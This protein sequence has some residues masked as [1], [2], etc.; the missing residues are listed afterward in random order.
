MRIAANLNVKDEIELIG[1][2]INHLFAIGVDVIN[3]FD[4]S[5]T[6]GTA[7]FLARNASD[8]LKLFSLTD[9][10]PNNF[11]PWVELS[12][13]VALAS[14]ADWVVFLDADE[15]WL[16][17]HG[18]IKSSSALEDAD[19]IHVDRFNVPLGVDGPMCPTIFAP[20]NYAC[21]MLITQPV[22]DFRGYLDV[23]PAAPWIRGV[24]G[25]KIM[26]RP[27]CIGDILC[28][29]HDVVPHP[30]LKVRRADAQDIIITHLPFT[31]RERFIRKVDNI[32]HV[33]ATHGD[34]FGQD[35]AWHWRRWLHLAEAGQLNA[36]FDRTVFSPSVTTELQMQGVIRSA[37]QIFADRDKTSMQEGVSSPV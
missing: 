4:I 36:E 18:S 7:E 1:R 17:L 27:E 33:L 11:R 10:E 22:P 16:P 25:R 9:D 8:R 12:I 19:I 14:K 29:H 37:R 3:A 31:Q 23:N 15:Y 34:Y 28:G 26:A 35:L 5:S 13:Q 2:T 20:M 32:R 24:P 30:G 6:D 21:I